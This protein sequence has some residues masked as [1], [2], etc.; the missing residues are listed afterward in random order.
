MADKLKNLLLVILLAVMIVLLVL[1]FLVSVR[2]SVAGR[3]L[4]QPLEEQDLVGTE[5]P[6]RTLAQP[7]VLTLIGTEGLYLTCEAQDYELLYQQTEPLFQ[8]AVGSAGELQALAEDAYLEMLTSSGVLLQYHDAQ[9]LWLIQ[10]WGGSGSIREGMDISAAAM[11]AHGEQVALLLTDREGNRWMAETAASLSEL[12]GLSAAGGQCNAL[13]AGR[14]DAVAADT[15][16]TTVVGRYPVLAT[17]QPELVTRGELSKSVQSL[18]GMNAYLTRVYQNTDGSLVYVES[19]STI[20]LT[21]S[22]DLTYTGTAGIDME[23][24]NAG[25]ARQAELCWK[26]YDLLYRLWE[27][28]GA[29]GTLSLEE[30]RLQGDSGTLQFGLQWGGLFLE[31]EEG[32]WATVTVE[33]GTIT[34][35]TA[36]LRLL[37]EG[38]TQQLLPLYQAEA[39][40]PRGRAALRVRLLEQADGTLMPRICRVTEE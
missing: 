30:V 18:F 10:A 40:L 5:V 26:V 25:T 20:S 31:R 35:L 38:E 21:P 9:P 13:F 1:T 15:V 34:G 14:D 29:S 11:V 39:V 32:S 17:Y 33:N 28:A 3:Q 2:G 19:H 16:L 36:A 27:Q 24:T 22:G 8:E 4:L 7:E 37:E 12:E 23:L 6:V